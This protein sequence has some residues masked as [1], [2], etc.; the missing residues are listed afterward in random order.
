MLIEKLK[1]NQKYFL[2][3]SMS[4]EEALRERNKTSVR[5][6]YIIEKCDD[7]PKSDNGWVYQHILVMEAKLGRYL[8]EGEEVHHDNEIKTDNRIE[9]L[10]LMTKSEH[11]SHHRKGKSSHNKGQH[12]DT[13]DRVCHLC[14]SDKT[15]KKKPSDNTTNVTPYPVWY[16]LPHD[17]ENWV[18]EKCYKREIY[19]LKRSK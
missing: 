11:M 1:A 19:R 7:H 15:Y 8:K 2:F 17:K 14:G 5:N 10:V 18:C 16:H 4:L 13:S 12:I 3:K 9:N 6:G